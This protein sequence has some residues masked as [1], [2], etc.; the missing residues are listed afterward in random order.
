MDRATILWCVTVFLG[1]SIAFQAIQTATE[2]SPP[3]VSLGLQ[4]AALALMIVAIVVFVRRRR[5]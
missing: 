2:D 3:G 5:P 4:T 1:A